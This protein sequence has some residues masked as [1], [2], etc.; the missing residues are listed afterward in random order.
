VVK[1]SGK[2]KGYKVLGVI[3]F[4]S[5]RFLSQTLTDR[6]NF[7]SYQAF[8]SY[9]LAQTDC[10]VILIQ[11]GARYHTSRSMRDFFAAHQDRLIV[12]QLPSYSPDTTRLS[13]YGSI[14]SSGPPTTST[15]P[16]LTS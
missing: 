8:L 11:D 15:S 16:S 2:R 5:G 3:E 9:V 10:T 4:F 7:G 14:S 1:T 13:S 6:F 12:Y